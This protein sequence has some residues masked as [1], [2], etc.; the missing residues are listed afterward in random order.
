MGLAIALTAA[1]KG[2][3]VA[4]YA[5]VVDLVKTGAPQGAAG[6]A[7]I[8]GAVIRDRETGRDVKVR[9]K[10]VINATGCFTDGVLKLD[11]PDLKNLVVPSK[12]L[13]VMLPGYFTP[14]Y[15]APQAAP[16]ACRC[17]PLRRNLY[18]FFFF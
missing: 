14:P 1:E 2:A 4:N 9:A 12:G 3:T 13:H 17:L 6:E 8:T 18:F 7:Q 11:E 10:A 15:V 16:A 5:E